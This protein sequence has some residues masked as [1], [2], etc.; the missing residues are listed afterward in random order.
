MISRANAES[1]YN[2]IKCGLC[3]AACPVYEQILEETASP[4]GKVQLLKA[5][6][7]RRLI[8]SRHL[9]E[10]AS[11]CLLCHSCAS[12]CPSGMEVGHLIAALRAEM[13]S[14]FGLEW[15]KRLAF[16]HLLSEK[17]H[18]GLAMKGARMVRPL[19]P[20]QVRVAGTPLSGYPSIPP[21]ALHDQV[22]ERIRPSGSAVK[23]TVAFFPG[24]M[25]AYIYPEIGRSFISLLN[26]LRV[27][28]IL[29]K[30]LVCCGTPLLISGEQE[31][32]AGNL[33]HNL[34]VL[35][36][37]RAE[38][39][40]TA[41]ASCGHTLKKE[42]A[43]LLREWGQDDALAQEV[44]SR[45]Q[46]VSQFLSRQEELS[47]ILGPLP[48]PLTYHDPCHLAKG[49]GVRAEPRALLRSIPEL[50][51]LEMAE[52][53]A[54]CGGGGS[55]Q[56]YFP[57][58][59]RPIVGAKVENIRRTKAQVVATGCPACRL[60]LESILKAEGS[61]IEVVHTVQVLERAMVEGRKS[62]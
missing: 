51:Y 5:L 40:L 39:I 19:L 30:D 34:E 32:L 58:I 2:C 53:D 37:L 52:A 46:D 4:R 41:C 36:S 42:Y 49:Q 59:S 31:M 13:V 11:R 16:R 26:A 55:F 22:P 14:S 12:V 54:C 44:G 62:R 25:I 17:G 43:Y 8:E 61:P 38:T 29:P 45:V 60:R 50:E 56:F 48:I 23:T 21:K 27:E 57:E 1:L 28:V 15:K 47:H 20:P 3:L 24:C 33:R 7:H 10:I 18:F 6:H 9:E 35:S